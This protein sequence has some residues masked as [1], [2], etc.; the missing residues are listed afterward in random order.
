MNSVRLGLSKLA[1]FVASAAF[2]ATVPALSAE[3]IVAITVVGTLSDEGAECP[4]LR[5]DDRKLYTL[6]P[7]SALGLFQAGTRVK[8]TGIVAEIS[9]CQQ[10][11]TI[12][13]T[14]VEPVK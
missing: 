13:V 3:A 8:V 9:I 14:T 12:E 5:G 1:A 2:V 4:A 11:T 7:R 10:G 6:T